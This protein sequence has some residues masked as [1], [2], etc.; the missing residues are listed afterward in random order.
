MSAET[1]EKKILYK[2][3]TL[4]A[5]EFEARFPE[6]A[7]QTD[8]NDSDKIRVALGLPA[9]RAKAGARAGNKNAVGNR[10]RWKK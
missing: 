9:R 7:A 1:S 10:G 3:I 5:G 4:E 6:I 8:L 2:T